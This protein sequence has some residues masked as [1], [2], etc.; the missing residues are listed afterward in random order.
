MPQNAM[1]EQFLA[2]GGYADYVWPAYGVAFVA[3]IWLLLASI[4]S[5]KKNESHLKQAREAR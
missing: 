2:M 3:L 5:A 1:I 4:K